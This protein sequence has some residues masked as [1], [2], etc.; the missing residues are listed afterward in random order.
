MW[1]PVPSIQFLENV[2]RRWRDFARNNTCG[3]GI[4][5]A[6]PQS[7]SASAT[8]REISSQ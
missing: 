5:A 7:R 6:L 8:P 1:L 4:L 2:Y 3:K